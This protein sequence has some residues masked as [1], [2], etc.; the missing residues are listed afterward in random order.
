MISI[1]DFQSQF[2]D[3]A[4]RN[5]L[6]NQMQSEHSAEALNDLLKRIIEGEHELLRGFGLP[7]T[8]INSKL[9]QYYASKN[10]LTL[11]D[12]DFLFSKL[13][14]V[15]AEY[16]LEPV[17]SDIQLL[18]VAQEK[19]LHIDDVLPNMNLK[20]KREPYY[21]YLYLEFFLKELISPRL[22]F[23]ELKI[24]NSNNLASRLHALS[25]KIEWRDYEE[26]HQLTKYGL[27]H[28]ED[29]L[30]NWEEF[31]QNLYQKINVSAY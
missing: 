19:M 25:K 15:A 13:K 3:Y 11:W 5:R 7:Y 9:V 14:L 31:E 28:L 20:L 8:L 22:F 16:V 1:N 30:S 29:F 10:N 2:L 12:I 24:V 6:W 21:L 18:T 4:A 27:K 23:E 17:A 26:Y